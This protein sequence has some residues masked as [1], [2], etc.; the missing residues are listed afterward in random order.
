[1]SMENPAT[2]Q[3]ANASLQRRATRSAL[4]EIPARL[5]L[6]TVDENGRT[7][8][9]TAAATVVGTLTPNTWALNVN[10]QLPSSYMSP[11]PSPDE[12]VI[13]Q[14]GRRRGPVN[15]SPDLDAHKREGIPMGARTPSPVKS[16]IVLRSTPRKRLMLSDPKELFTTPEKMRKLSPSLKGSPGVKKG[17]VE[18]PTLTYNGPIQLGLKGLSQEQLIGI[19]QSLIDRH[20]NLEDEVRDIMPGPDLR[21]L[22]EQ[23]SYLKKNIFKSLPTSRL[24]SK[25]DSP[26]Y[27]RAAVHLAAFKKFVLEQGRQLVE[28][29]HWEAV[30]DY[31]CLAWAY[32]RATPLWDNPPHN[33]TRKQCFKSLVAQCMAAIKRGQWTPQQ[34]DAMVNRL[35]GF[36][37]DS[38][39]MEMCIKQLDAMHRK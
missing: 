20:P 24:T 3:V 34:C 28:S 13:Q 7:E 2:P 6:L 17:R 31:V 8:G 16:N 27:S 22:E 23:L 4:A 38:E 15:W 14:R 37:A 39:D 11:A 19:V 29:C 25:T 32:V 26:A 12:L 21:P 36:T 18:K 30:V 1:M 5:G 9:A 10:V 33:A 35:S